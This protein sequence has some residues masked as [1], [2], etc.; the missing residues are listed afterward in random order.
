MKEC[1]KCNKQYEDTDAFCPECGS[2]LTAVQPQPVTPAKPKSVWFEYFM[3][4]W[5]IIVGAIAY[6]ISYWVDSSIGGLLC[7]ATVIGAWCKTNGEPNCKNM[8]VKVL[9]TALG[10]FHIIQLIQY[11][12]LF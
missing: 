7:V 10:V 12:L 9:G 6:A 11:G 5:P 8:T 2:E 4:F 1:T 3:K